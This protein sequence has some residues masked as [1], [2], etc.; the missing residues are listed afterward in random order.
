MK[1][2][3]LFKNA[4]TYG[5]AG[6]AA[7]AATTIAAPAIAQGRIEWRMGTSWPKGMGGVQTGA[8]RLA[9]NIGRMTD[10]KLTIR[11]FSAGEVVP[12]LQGFDAVSSGTLDCYHDA[13]YYHIGKNQ[14]CQFFTCVPFGFTANEQAAW[15]NHGGGQALWDKLYAQYN[16]KAFIA[17]NTGTQ[18]LGWYRTEVKSVD[19]YKGKKLRMPGWGGAVLAKLGAQ[20]V[21]L[22][23]GEI[24]AALQAGAVDGA[25]WIGP[26]ND[27]ALGFHQVAKICYGPGFHEPG[28]SLQMMMNKAKWDALPND[29]KAAVQVA[30]GWAH[31]DMWAEY[32]IRSAEAM[33]VL[34]NQHGVRFLRTPRDILIAF[35][36]AAREYVGEIRERADPVTK[37]IF[38]SYLKARTDMVQYSR[39]AEGAYLDA[40]GL[41]FEYIR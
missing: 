21:V 32:T 10:G 35:G 5:V 7:A 36:N 3:S 4:G 15:I 29:L 6:V 31:D 34:R 2:R 13:S 11:V 33:N 8:E 16:L 24:F 14:G 20:Q 37:E 19:D 41:P 23:G 26:Y 30:C 27:L 38:A 18:A 40:R 25:E 17:G 12:A 28:S 39:F 1:R 22:P 9:A